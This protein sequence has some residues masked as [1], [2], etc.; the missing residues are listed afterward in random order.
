MLF[1][2]FRAE[3]VDLSEDHIQCYKGAVK[4]YVY[5]INMNSTM[6]DVP[7]GSMHKTAVCE[8]HIE[9]LVQNL[10][11]YLDGVVVMIKEV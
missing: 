3:D 4:E 6:T 2:N 5:S 11:E 10:N 1:C 8:D 7:I 9:N